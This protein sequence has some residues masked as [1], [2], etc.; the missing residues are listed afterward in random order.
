L[1][2]ARA[3]A[4]PPRRAT[5]RR[6]GLSTAGIAVAAECSTEDSMNAQS[7][8]STLVTAAVV[9]VI[10]PLLATVAAVL[11]HAGLE[12][13]GGA[14]MGMFAHVGF[15][16]AVVLVWSALAVAIVT[17]LIASL[18]RNDAHA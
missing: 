1:F 15:V 11:A 18:L 6:F 16:Q 7:N 5:P 2:A 12:V 8:V 14:G 3:A 4:R 13:T 10:L 9:L 17:A